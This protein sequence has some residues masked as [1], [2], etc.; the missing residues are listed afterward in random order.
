MQT[1]GDRI[2]GRVLEGRYRI[3]HQLARGGMSTVYSALDE[4]LDRPV[5]VKV[6]SAAL[7]TDPAFAD[8]FAREARVAA[9]LS[10]LNAVA[11]YDQGSD[12]GHVFLVM[13]LVRGRTLRDLLRERGALPPAL[14]VS[15]ME[16]VLGALAAAH[17]AGLVHRDVKPENILLSDDGAVKVAD[18]GLA[19]AIEADPSSTRTGLMMGTVAYC[20]PEQISRGSAD[21]RSDVYSAGVVLFELLT[22]A[23]PYTGDSAMAVAYQ[24][25]NSDVPAPST[26]RP[27]IPPQLDEIVLRAA[28]REPGGRP[29]DA[30]ALLAELHDARIDLGLPVLG[31]PPRPDTAGAAAVSTDTQR[32]TR[33]PEG[34][35]AT[36]SSATAP[37]PAR[38]GATDLQHTTVHQLDRSQRAGG[39]TAGADRPPGAGPASSRRR[40]NRRRTAVVVTIVLLLGLLTGYG[41]WYLAVG[42]YHE[43]PT[44]AGASRATAVQQL[45]DA[46]FTVDPT[47]DQAFSETAAAGAVLG[48]HPDAGT[49]LLGGRSVRLVISSGAERFTVPQVAGRDYAEAQQ[50][51]AEIPVRLVRRNAADGTGKLAPGKVIR[52]EPQP[53]SKVKRDSVVTVYVS[54]GPP[55]VPVPDV[56]DQSQDQA[57]ATLTKA[58]F[59]L[60]LGQEHSDT[61]PAGSVIRQ[62]P[63][64]KSS[65][66]KFSTV[67]LVISQG[68]RLVTLPQIRN[69]T[70]IAEAR[71]RLEAL[72]LKVR[73]KR[74]FGG[75]LGTVV[76]M[77]PG[78]GTQV[79]PGAEV[80]LT[81][82]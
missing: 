17:R 30:G 11:V 24:H 36:A 78:A 2:V 70:P 66:A 77:D 26:R 74:A 18:F 38:P 23:P 16:P 54:T 67:N 21:A 65:V 43:V 8:R 39:A 68:P 40:R 73:V 9:R 62:D 60:A 56:R 34:G 46:G 61:V 15:I 53:T 37:T 64:A 81:V 20:P 19:R 4:R 48:T 42:R 10:H 80:L 33:L 57:S 5:A 79:R 52:T 31:V 14:A 41:A 55:I 12:D 63:S 58:G 28:N 71:G 59:K 7:S 51:F 27:G 29:L 32:I 50:S 6:M 25:V 1:A 47:V 45:R 69:G 3:L 22:G 75:F 76:G 35:A 49:H 13:E 44:V 82:V 72:G